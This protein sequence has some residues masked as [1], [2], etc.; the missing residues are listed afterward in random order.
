MKPRTPTLAEALACADVWAQS[1]SYSNMATFRRCGVVMAAHI[2]T[3]EAENEKLHAALRDATA[4]KPVEIAPP[5]LG[6]FTR[7][8]G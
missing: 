6:W 4:P 2:R 8:F 1:E 5:K 7:T 3:L